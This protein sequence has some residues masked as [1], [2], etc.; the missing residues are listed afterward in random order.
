MNLDLTDITVLLDRSGSMD[1]VREDTI[2]GVNS[3]IEEQQKQP[4]KAN[5]T[6][7]QFDNQY[8]P[9]YVAIDVQKAD[10]LSRRTYSP[11]GSTR[12]L[13]AIGRAIDETGERLSLIPEEQRPGKVIFVIQTDGEENASTLYAGDEGRK[14]I[15]EKITHQTERYNWQFVF[16]GANQD[17]ITIAESIGI[18]AKSS[19]TY[20]SK[21]DGTSKAYKSAA[22]YVTKMRCAVTQDD[23]GAVTFSDA[24]RDEQKD[25]L[26]S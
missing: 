16:L 24:E 19:L 18:M 13:D 8:E 10:K 26:K 25:L 3:F 15:N 22:N 11:R 6:L 2:G 5:L 20:A 4:G 23:M 1:S 14:R 21:L 9:N 17:A 7:I 12:L